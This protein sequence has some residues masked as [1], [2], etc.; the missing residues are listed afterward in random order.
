MEVLLCVLYKRLQRNTFPNNYPEIFGTTSSE[1]RRVAS[2]YFTLF[3]FGQRLA[4][5]LTVCQQSPALFK[6]VGPRR[7]RTWR[8]ANE[9]VECQSKAKTEKL[10]LIRQKLKQQFVNKRCRI[11]A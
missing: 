2:N 1:G 7:M 11:D 5:N 6:W 8:C 3:H 10:H 9:K 4:G